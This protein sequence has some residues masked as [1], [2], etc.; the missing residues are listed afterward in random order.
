M[1]NIRTYHTLE[2]K[3]VREHV[4][5]Q[6]DCQENSPAFDAM[7]ACYDSILPQVMEL[8]KPAAVMCT[9]ILPREAENKA[10][11]EVLY[12]IVTMGQ[13]ISRYISDAFESGDYVRGL[14]AD[15]MSDDALFSAVQELHTERLAFCADMKRGICGSWDIPQDLPAI[16]LQDAWTQT[17]AAHIGVK[18][19]SGL[20]F[21]PV[22]TLCS[23]YVL[24]HQTE[25]FRDWHDCGRC[26]KQ[27]CRF[28]QEEGLSDKSGG[29]QVTVVKNGRPAAVLNCQ[30]GQTVMEVLTEFDASYKAVCGGSGRCGKCRIKLI[31]GS[32]A[33]SASDRKF[34]SAKELDQGRRL[35][36]M[37]VPDTD[38]VVVP[39]METQ[40]DM[41]V[42][43]VFGTA[44][45]R[46]ADSGCG[47]A[48]NTKKYAAAIDIGTT[49]LAV[50][51]IALPE[52]R[53]MGTYTGIN[54][55]RT[56]GADVIS[57]IGWACAGKEQAMRDLIE[58]DVCSGIEAA[59]G[60]YLPEGGE[61]DVIA[62]CGNTTMLHIFR[63]YPCNG[64]GQAPFVPYTLKEEIF[65][66][67]GRLKERLQAAGQRLGRKNFFSHV[68]IKIYPGISAFVGA[69]IVAGMCALNMASDRETD[70][71][72]DLGTNGE[73]AIGNCEKLL[74]TSAAAG[75]A[76]EGGNITWGTGSVQGAI[77][78]A[79][80]ENGKLKTETIGGGPPEGICG[81][82]L[83][84]ITSELLKAGIID[85]NGMLD[86]AY[87][88]GGYP[89]A[90]R[91]DGQI[92]CL[93]QK[94][95]RELQMAKAA[96][97]AAAQ[98]LMIKYHTDPAQIRHIYI[99]GGFGYQLNYEKAADIGLFPKAFLGKM[100]AVGN[101][102]LRGAVMLAS[103]ESMMARADKITALATET[104]LASEPV[105]QQKYMEGMYF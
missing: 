18:I 26:Q 34:F 4:F 73:M 75:P 87:F 33:V 81:T 6:I 46:E 23:V 84:E 39:E 70:M 27:S 21:D 60:L 89:V 57:R 65:C 66:P 17:E 101:S 71:L 68:C 76:F 90:K 52:G 54:R 78:R 10:G 79:V 63:G 25:K 1:E 37:A 80:Y 104:G 91:T 103:D 7:T 5:R 14:M 55:Q 30:P 56:Y 72:I 19:G 29:C 97:C 83:I 64:L 45:C 96:V 2:V 38:I 59:A 28:R 85:E 8:L 86:D 11:T 94:D 20:M 58:E 42:V 12:E 77:C 50:Q 62:V 43:S 88:V 53:I 9:A 31:K 35:A 32:L 100:T 92:I 82:G 48:D 93:T 41:A 13:G 36:C 15:A 99:A 105:F 61:L 67:E 98:T 51:M 22:K 3:I 24:T 40:E 47:H 74:V 69:D 102:A 49:T 44:A 16:I 95:I